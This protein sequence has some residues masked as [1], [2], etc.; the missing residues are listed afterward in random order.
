MFS[1][2]YSIGLSGMEGHLVQVETD[3]SDGLPGFYVSGALSLEVKESPDRVRTALKNSGYR[4]PSKK[5]TVNL[6]PADR[7]KNGTGFDLPIAVAVL[8]AAGVVASSAIEKAIFIGELGLDGEVK[9]VRGVLSMVLTAKEIG[10]RR[11][12]L[13]VDNVAEG[14]GIPDMEIIGIK[15]LENM[16]DRLNNREITGATSFAVEANP[17]QSVHGMQE[18]SL[19]FSEVKGQQLL[20]R[21]TETAVAGQHNILYIGPPGTGKT[22]IAKRIPTIMP[23]MSIDEMMEISKIYSVCG[24]LPPATSLLSVRPFRNPHYFIS[25]QAFVGGGLNPK[26]GELSLASRGVLFLD[27]LPEFP[28][29]AIESLRQPLE[30]HKV[31]VTRVRGNYDFPANFMLVGAMNPCNCGYYPDRN[32]CSCTESQIRKY[33]GKVS[34]PILDRIDICVEAAPVAYEELQ[35]KGNGEDSE[36]IRERV[37]R[38]RVIQAERFAGSGIYFNSEMREK[39]MKTYC[40][41]LPEDEAFFRHLFDSMGLSARA[42]GKILKVARTIADLEG[43]IHIRKRHLCEAIGYRSLEDKYWGGESL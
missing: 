27:E 43:E 41:L 34:K 6:S 14:R 13:P 40:R 3:V 23:V 7:R 11:C 12:F 9:P 19:D 5:V 26:P 36:T 24:L 8:C 22:M 39:E 35:G 38:A 1:K 20:R 4:L 28:R 21:A 2:V 18:K 10:I 25:R 30:E 37:E 31:T 42:Y 33:M 17:A 32:R 29:W 16:V 15:T